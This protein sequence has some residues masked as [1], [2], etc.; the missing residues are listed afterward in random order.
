MPGDNGNNGSRSLSK[1]EMVNFVKD[2]AA[3]MTAESCTLLSETYE[4]QCNNNKEYRR[5]VQELCCTPCPNGAGNVSVGECCIVFRYGDWVPTGK[6]C[7]ELEAKVN[8]L[9][10]APPRIA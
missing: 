10:F 6:V 4:Y 3:K 1:E 5:L 2:L 8:E 7:G 9:L